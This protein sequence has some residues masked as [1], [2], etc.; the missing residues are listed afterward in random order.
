MSDIEKNKVI[1]T[2]Y[3]FIVILVIGRLFMIIIVNNKIRFK[4][5]IYIY[6]Y[7][8]WIW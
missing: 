3:L 2:E 8:Y 6:I 1:L 5:Y 4:S 7:I